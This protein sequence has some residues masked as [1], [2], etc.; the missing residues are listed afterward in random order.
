METRDLR[1]GRAE[2]PEPLPKPPP[3]KRRRQLGRGYPG[4]GDP[5]ATEA[6]L[7]TNR[8]P[9]ETTAIAALRKPQPPPM[10]PRKPGPIQ[11][12]E[13]H[14]LSPSLSRRRSH[15]LRKSSPIPLAGVAADPA[16]VELTAPPRRIST[17]ALGRSHVGKQVVAIEA[18]G[19]KKTSHPWTPHENGPRSRNRLQADAARAR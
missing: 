6:T 16:T 13:H 7:S 4:P 10:P 5:H 15:V 9:A 12:T 1:S 18:A 2:P 17:T 14:H 11:T 8:T 19:P 3:R